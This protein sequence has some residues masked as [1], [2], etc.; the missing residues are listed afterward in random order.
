MN[1]VDSYMLHASL[2]AGH[3]WQGMSH[4]GQDLVLHPQARNGG[5]A[6]G[7]QPALVEQRQDTAF[8]ALL[9]QRHVSARPVDQVSGY[10]YSS[11]KPVTLTLWRAPDE[12]GN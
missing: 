1:W 4:L 11:G 10:N 2:P 5:A 7:S 8:R 9:A 12:T 6:P 3:P